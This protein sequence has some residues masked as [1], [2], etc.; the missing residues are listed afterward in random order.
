[1]IDIIVEFLKALC[2]AYSRRRLAKRLEIT[3]PDGTACSHQE[4]QKALKRAEEQALVRQAYGLLSE[5][6]RC[7]VSFEGG[8]IKACPL[9]SK[10]GQ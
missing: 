1:M 6:A 4:I 8:S 10:N 2:G 5:G 7:V 9:S 3:L